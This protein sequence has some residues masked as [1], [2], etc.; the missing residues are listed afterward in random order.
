MN[1]VAFDALLD[2]DDAVLMRTG[3]GLVGLDALLAQADVV[4]LH[5]PLR[6]RR[7]ATC[8]MRGAWRR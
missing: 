7:R 4:T 1:V 5:V 3:V 6:P 2:P 8:S